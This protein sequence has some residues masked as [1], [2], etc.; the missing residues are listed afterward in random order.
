MHFKNSRVGRLEQRCQPQNGFVNNLE[1]EGKE[2][3]AEK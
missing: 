3:N 2:S 1:L